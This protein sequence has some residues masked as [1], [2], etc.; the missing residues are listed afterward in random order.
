[1]C[2]AFGVADAAESV[3]RSRKKD[4]V[5]VITSYPA[6]FYEPLREDFERAND[7]INLRIINKKTTAAIAHIQDRPDDPADVFWASAPDAFEVLKFAGRLA[8]IE[9]RSTGA[10][11]RI[12]NYPI[13][14]PDGKYLGFALS[15]FGLLWNPSY[16]ERNHIPVPHTWDDLRDPAYHRHIGISSPSRSGTMH[17][18][19]ETVLQVNGWDQG[20]ATWLEIAGNLATVTAR[21]FGVAD[22]IA[23][24]RFGIGVTIDFLGQ[25]QLPAGVKLRFAYP[26]SNVFLPASVALLRDAPNRA[27]AE[28]FIDFLFSVHGQTLLLHPDIQRLPIMPSVYEHADAGQLNPYHTKQQ[29]ERF[30]FNR[31]ISRVRYE[32]V[33]ILFDELITLRVSD[34]NRLWRLIHRSE[35]RLR[36]QP[37]VE[38]ARLVAEARRTIQTMPVSEA[39]AND[40][41]YATGLR[42]ITPGQLVPQRHA[43]LEAELRTYSRRTLNGARE[44]ALAAAAR[45]G[46][47]LDPE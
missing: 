22:G 17:L 3:V 18:M 13:N 37:D 11:D 16:L 19:V 43:E 44:F 41:A 6:S 32:L 8:P 14:D 28:K 9:P 24:G 30:V 1:M 46:L 27:G 25:A 2:F 39:Q 29:D 5:T 36:A 45:L 34:L 40:R 33:N 15:G 4:I 12:G 35:E 20:W 47:S 23:R 10:P 42:R 26:P 7:S 21:S 38:A 31:E